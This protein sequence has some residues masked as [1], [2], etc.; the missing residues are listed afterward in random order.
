LPYVGRLGEL[1]Q[2]GGG[3]GKVRVL[4]WEGTLNLLKADPLRTVIGYGPETMQLMYG[5]YYPVDL[6]HYE[7]R[8]IL[9]DRSHNETFD[10]LVNTGVVGFI[11][12]M[13]L[14]GSIFYYGIK[15]LGFME[16]ERQRILFLLLV[17]A[18]ALSGVFLPK[19]IEGTYRLSGV[20]LP[21]GFI[22]AAC[23]YFML[24]AL[25]FPIRERQALGGEKQLLL[26]ALFSAIVAH[27]I[28]IHFGIAIAATRVY[29]WIYTA[30]FVVIGLNRFREETG[31]KTVPAESRLLSQQERSSKRAREAKRQGKQATLTAGGKA[32]QPHYSLTARLL[33][34]SL[35][36]A[37]I[38]FI[39]GIELCANPDGSV[40]VF[41]IIQRSL[42]TI[43]PT[44]NVKSSYGIP[45]MFFLTWLAG[46]L[47]VFAEI[48]QTAPSRQKVNG[49]ISPFALYAAVTLMVFFSGVVIQASLIKPDVDSAATVTFY[50]GAIAVLCLLM[51]FSL[52]FDIRLPERVW[53]KSTLWTYPVLIVFVCLVIVFTNVN[54]VKADVYYKQGL[55]VEKE[56]RWDETIQFFDKAI[57]LN[58]FQD[59][60]HT[61]LSRALIGKSN[62]I[63]NRQEKSRVFEEIFKTLTRAQRLNPLNPDHYANLGLLYLKWAEISSSQEERTQRLNLADVYY[64]KS[65]ERD[66]YNTQIFNCWA[67]VSIERNDYDGAHKKLTYSLSLDKRYGYTHFILGELYFREGKLSEA[68]DA[69]RQSISYD[70]NNALVWCSFGYAY[71]RQG[72]LQDARDAFLEAIRL[73]PR[74]ANAHSNLGLVYFKLGQMQ[75]AIEENLTVIQIR[76]DDLITHRNLALLY[77][78]VKQND[79]ALFY[80][81]EALRLSPEPEKPVMQNLVDQLKAQKK[82]DQS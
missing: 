23:L 5:P 37:I 78:Q 68:V 25:L 53:R 65:A 61:D 44:G 81:Q 2:T 74:L 35:L 56:Q 60:F 30:L 4:I 33:A 29:F 62:A 22:A 64:G 54:V 49:W 10:V 50:Y 31:A 14:F 45:W 76:P 57:S 16:T 11:V 69:Y 15:W 7:G 1:S 13:F 18:G 48:G 28:E 41:S 73:D 51:A 75:Q 42:T 43:G 9:P 59:H 19:L 26:I 32:G 63:D 77:L 24:S 82:S 71:L 3:T 38:L 67:L 66:P 72:N 20:G 58:P 40:D 52:M 12:Y 21:V 39:L 27:F 55:R 6:V 17:I 47:V 36:V 34:G 80:A 46:E 70:P 8:N 79:K